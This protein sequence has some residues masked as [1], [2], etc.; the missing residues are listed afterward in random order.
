MTGVPSTQRVTSHQLRDNPTTSSGD[1]A[2]LSGLT[3]GGAL[4]RLERLK[5][6][7]ALRR[8]AGPGRRSHVIA[9]HAFR[10]A[11]P[12]APLPSD[13]PPTVLA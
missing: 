1:V 12:F 10:P 13:A 11:P 7:D 9:G 2:A 3:A 5:A 6:L 8:E 4:R